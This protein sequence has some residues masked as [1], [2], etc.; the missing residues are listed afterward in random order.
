[1][2]RTIAC[3]AV[4]VLLAGCSAS[5]GPPTP[6]ASSSPEKPAS[7]ATTTQ[8]DATAGMAAPGTDKGPGTSPTPPA[9][10]ST[11]DTSKPAPLAPRG[12]TGGPNGDPKI[13]PAAATTTKS[14]PDDPA[15]TVSDAITQATQARRV[16]DLAQA[17]KILEEAMTKHSGNRQTL[18]LLAETYQQHGIQ[19]AQAGGTDYS[20]FVKSAQQLRKV[21]EL[22]PDMKKP[23]SAQLQQFV[24]TVLYNE[25]C[26]FARGGDSDKA[27]ASLREALDAGFNQRELFDTDEDLK[28]LREL[29][30]FKEL[31]EST[32]KKDPGDK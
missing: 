24:S 25:A 15:A 26:A 22:Q 2:I 3:V 4:L 10:P 13:P 20:Y 6:T 14:A 9:A 21:F 16:G 30:E 11:A 32:R 19:L 23:A 8:A 18:L 29:P 31:K 12:T 27:M 5:I 17:E 7:A 28:S 1:M